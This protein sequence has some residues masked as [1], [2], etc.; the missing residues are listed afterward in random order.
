MLL[1]GIEE[2]CRQEQELAEE[3]AEWINEDVIAGDQHP[4]DYPIEDCCLLK[5]FTTHDSFAIKTFSQS[6]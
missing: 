3:I 2:E 4:T 1:D 6:I 5:N